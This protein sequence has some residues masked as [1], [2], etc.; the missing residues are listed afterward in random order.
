MRLQFIITLFSESLRRARHRITVVTQV[1]YREIV[2]PSE[3][4]INAFL[5]HPFSLSEFV[6]R[7]HRLIPAGNLRVALPLRR[8]SRSI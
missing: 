5:D 7:S 6:V 1:I 8:L 4:P 3:G 2:S